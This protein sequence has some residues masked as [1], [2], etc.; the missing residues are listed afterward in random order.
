MRGLTIIVAVL[1]TLYSGYWFVARAA[2]S[3]GTDALIETLRDG[4]WQVDFASLSTVGFPNRIDTTAT[5]LRLADPAGL[6]WA[7]PFF[8]VFALSY[9]PNEIIAVWPDEQVLT[10]AG[11]R[12]SITSQGLRA[13]ARIG[14]STAL[15]LDQVT[16]E[17]G[18]M[19]VD[20]DQG[21]SVSLDRALTAF[22]RAGPVPATYDA[23]AEATALVPPAVLVARID[24]EGNLPE[25]VSRA[26]M[27]AGLTFDRPLDRFTGEDGP[28]LTALDLREMVLEWGD[29]TLSAQGTLTVD[30]RGVPDG[31]ITLS[32]TNW[33][34]LLDLAVAAGAFSPDVAP[35]WQAMAETMSGGTDQIDLPVTFQNGLMSMGFIPLG[36][37]PLLR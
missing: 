5:E 24:P 25:T 8:Q 18:P 26:R 14:I 2:V 28:L 15:P 6:A 12:L 1:T 30:A 31:R 9:R 4:G 22:R 21:W 17:S 19:R 34:G 23:F 10:L 7:A 35:T 32:V 37:A 16:A 11:Q 27:D 13:S 29:I 36:P 20:S 33:R 3:Q